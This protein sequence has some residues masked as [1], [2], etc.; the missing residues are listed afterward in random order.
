MQFGL[1]S[2]VLDDGSVAAT[3]ETVKVS[4]ATQGTSVPGTV[5]PRIETHSSRICHSGDGFWQGIERSSEVEETNRSNDL[6]ASAANTEVPE[7]G[8]TTAGFAR[9]PLHEIC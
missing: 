2:G 1:S 5:H 3:V 9:R 7:H 6:G 4:D 8:V